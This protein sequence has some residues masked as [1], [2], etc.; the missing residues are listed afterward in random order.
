MASAVMSLLVVPLPVE[1]NTVSCAVTVTSTP[2]RSTSLSSGVVRVRSDV[3]LWVVPF[4]VM[5]RT[6]PPST[7][8]TAVTSGR[9]RIAARSAGSS[10][11]W[12]SRLEPS[13]SIGVPKSTTISV[14][15]SFGSG[16]LPT[17]AVKVTSVG[18]SSGMKSP[19]WPAATAMPPTGLSFT[20]MEMVAWELSPSSSTM[21]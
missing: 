1:P 6:E 16:G 10:C 12:V 5:V 8:S 21:V 13:R 17:A 3:K 9:A 11:H 15:T 18:M 14:S 2:S 20:R 7:R 4:R 19:V